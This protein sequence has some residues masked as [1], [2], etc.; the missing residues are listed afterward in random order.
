LSSFFFLN[1]GSNTSL[2]ELNMLGAKNVEGLEKKYGG[3][4]ISIESN[5]ICS[6]K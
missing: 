3:F 2:D 4:G 5:I 1:V 6:I